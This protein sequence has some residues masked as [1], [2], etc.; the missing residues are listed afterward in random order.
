[1]VAVC[2]CGG[3]LGDVADLRRKIAGH[4]I[5]RIGQVFP[6]ASDA[7]DVR[8]ATEFSLGAYF[9]SHARYFRGER[10]ELIDHGVDRGFQ[11]ADFA[12]HID[13]DLLRE[14]AGRDGGRDF[15]NVA[16]LASEIAGHEIHGISQVLP[17][18]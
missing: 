14:V 17:R 5:H 9:A 10:A 12:F 7:F 3:D 18:T 16:D 6:G 1:K 11:F 15:G 13:G 2:D 8:L 4:R